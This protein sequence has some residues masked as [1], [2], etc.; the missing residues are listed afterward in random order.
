MIF[1]FWVQ[2][3]YFEILVVGTFQ[4]WWQFSFDL[5]PPF[6]PVYLNLYVQ[7]NFLN[8]LFLDQASCACLFG[9]LFGPVH[10]DPSIST[11]LF[12]PLY[13]SHNFPTFP[14][15]PT[16]PTFFLHLKKTYLTFPFWFLSP[17]WV[18]SGLVWS[19]LQHLQWDEAVV[20]SIANKKPNNQPNNN[21]LPEYSASPDFCWTV[22]LDFKSG[23]RQL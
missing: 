6:G 22:L 19:V 16:F 1:L 18:F 15:Y 21:N 17:Y 2:R 23:D 8:H 12:G 5:D 13:L 11:R 10:L 7:P 9:H 20:T 3:H 14:T 4:F